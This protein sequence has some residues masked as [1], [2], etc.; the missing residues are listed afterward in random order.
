MASRPDDGEI[1]A[2]DLNVLT[3]GLSG[4]VPRA[5]ARR[6][7]AIDVETSRD[8]YAVG[9]PIDIAV[10]LRNRIPFPVDVPTTGLRVWGW[11]VD[12]LLEATDERVYEPR[13]PR[14]F[15]MQARETRTFEVEW[16]GRIKR[17]GTPT[18]W[19][20]AGPGTHRIEAFLAVEP[21]RTDET[22][23]ELR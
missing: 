6:A 23:I 15:T 21:E 13:E 18:R 1:Q 3:R 5:V 16:D 20:P 4:F 10:T 12:G 7:V 17:E 2:R 9:E 19:E 8:E 22:T 11:R 14:S